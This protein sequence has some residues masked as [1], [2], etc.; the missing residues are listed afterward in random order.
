[1]AQNA[2]DD[3]LTDYAEGLE[4]AQQRIQRIVDSYQLIN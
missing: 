1:M 3:Y 2:R 4:L